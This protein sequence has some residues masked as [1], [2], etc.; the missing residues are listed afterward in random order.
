MHLRHNDR[1]GVEMGRKS[2]ALVTCVMLA[3]A[4]ASAAQT[5]VAPKPETAAPRKATG[6]AA[7]TQRSR[8]AATANSFCEQMTSGWVDYRPMYSDTPAAA[9]RVGYDQQ[10]AAMTECGAEQQRRPGDIRTAFIFARTLEVNGQGSRAAALYRQLAAAG[11]TQAKTQLARTLFFGNG[12]PRDSYAA[13]DLYVDAAKAGDSWAYNGAA[14][15][16]SFWDYTH[17]PRL[18][19]RYF[20]QAQRSGTFQTTNV[21]REDY[22]Q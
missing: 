13:C 9:G 5:F 4:S 11:Y 20:D 18:A 1:S 10:L 2:A 15:C 16:L 7:A 8:P 6:G 3:F 17:D 21:T 19:C 12:V 14:N 22:C